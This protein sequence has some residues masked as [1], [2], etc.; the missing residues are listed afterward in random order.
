MAAARS[1]DE[2]IEVHEAYL[3]SIQRQ[4]FVVPDKL[5]SNFALSWVFFFFFCQYYICL[6]L[7]YIGSC[8][9]MLSSF[10]ALFAFSG[11]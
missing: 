9:E 5:V 7:F 10:N 6:D 4:C 3:L 1:L 2:V 8:E 11:L